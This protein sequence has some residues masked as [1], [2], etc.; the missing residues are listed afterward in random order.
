MINLEEKSVHGDL[1]KSGRV[2]Q[3]EGR[4]H[5]GALE[6]AQLHTGAVPGRKLGSAAATG[7]HF[8]CGCCCGGVFNWEMRIEMGIERKRGG[9]LGTR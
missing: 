3:L 2:Q 4:L 6:S 5:R 7:L 1:S 9:G 8:P